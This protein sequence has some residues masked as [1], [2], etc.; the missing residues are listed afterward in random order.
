[1]TYVTWPQVIP[2]YNAKLSW[3]RE[4]GYCDDVRPRH[5]QSNIAISAGVGHFCGPR[6]ELRSDLSGG[7]LEEGAGG[8]ALEEGGEINSIG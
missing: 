6:Q 3:R 8:K 4:S 5:P 2:T 7:G 1:M